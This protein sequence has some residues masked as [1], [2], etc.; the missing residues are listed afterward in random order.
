METLF[1]RVLTLNLIATT[2]VFYE[3]NQRRHEVADSRR[4]SELLGQTRMRLE[5]DI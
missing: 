5:P 3:S 1:D 2:V 4:T